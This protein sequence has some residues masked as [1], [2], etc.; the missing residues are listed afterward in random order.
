MTR[1]NVFNRRVN[2]KKSIVPLLILLNGLLLVGCGY[3][4]GNANDVDHSDVVKKEKVVNEVEAKQADETE[5]KGQYTYEDFQGTYA[6]YE[7]EPYESAIVYALILTDDQYIDIVPEWMEYA[8]FQ[9]ETTEVEGEALTL[10]YASA[11]NDRQTTSTEP[12][13]LELNADE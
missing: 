1:L 4:N 10:T 7:G 3:T 8:V 2:M 9:V 12:L 6:L 13:V 5:S 11:E